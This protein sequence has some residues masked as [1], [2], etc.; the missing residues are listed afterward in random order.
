MARMDATPFMK[1]EGEK[2][3]ENIV[4]DG[5]FCGIFRTVA[6]IGDS[7]ASGEFEATNEDGT[8]SVNDFVDYSWGQ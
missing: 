6:V 1:I 4:T 8:T 5:G 3:L 7:L 2:P